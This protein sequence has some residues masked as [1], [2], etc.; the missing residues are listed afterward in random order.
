MIFQD[1]NSFAHLDVWTNVALGVSPRLDLDAGQRQR[2]DAALD[3][4]G[5]LALRHRKPGE[6]SGGERQ[7]IA[8]A[9]A[10]VRDRPVLLLDEPFTALGPGLRREML[11]LL[12]GIRRERSLTIL[13]VTHD[14]GDARAAASHVAYVEGGRIVAKRPVKAFFRA[15]DI[16]G[17]ARYIGPG[18]L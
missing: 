10:V 4:V 11:D 12:Q 15:R 3:R 5:I 18:S 17:L 1:H 9:R 13:L 16:P 2:V 14:P 8:I 6:I 7:R